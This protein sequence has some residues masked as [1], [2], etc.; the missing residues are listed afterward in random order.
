MSKSK[1][2][3]DDFFRL[4]GK[5]WIYWPLGFIIVPFCGFFAIAFVGCFLLFGSE[6]NL[7]RALFHGFFCGVLAAILGLIAFLIS[8]IGFR[9]W[10]LVSAFVI[11][12]V[13][14]GGFWGTWGWFK[15]ID[16]FGRSYPDQTRD[17]SLLETLLEWLS[18]VVKGCADVSIFP[19]I[20]IGSVLIVIYLVLRKR[21]KY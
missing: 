2:K 14:V 7:D 11:P 21:F 4:A 1:N 16:D 8:L 12:A 15:S 3:I 20:S 13:T 18:Y 10:F 6:M 17:L 5:R 19:A 9:H